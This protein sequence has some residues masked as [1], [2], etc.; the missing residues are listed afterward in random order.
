M[1]ISDIAIDQG[2][3]DALHTLFKSS[4]QGRQG[5]QGYSIVSN[6]SPQ[7]SGWLI[8][9]DSSPQGIETRP[10]VIGAAAISKIQLDNQFK[11]YLHSFL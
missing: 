5:P 9:E 7:D 6:T 2:I 8:N 4:P 3:Q 10:M 1:Q 11:N